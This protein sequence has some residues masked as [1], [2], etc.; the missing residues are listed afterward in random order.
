M[1]GFG[2]SGRPGD[3]EFVSAVVETDME[4][5]LTEGLKASRTLRELKANQPHQLHVT[6]NTLC[7][8]Y[9]KW[10]EVGPRLDSRQPAG[11]SCQVRK[12]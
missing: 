8:Q 6:E 11:I 2:S 10:V 4:H 7:L 1:R 5:L 9:G 3:R 12:A